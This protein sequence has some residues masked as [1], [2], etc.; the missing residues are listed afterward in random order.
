MEEQYIEERKKF[1]KKYLKS[2]EFKEVREA[3]FARDGYRCVAC[4]REGTP[5]N[6]LVCHH[7]CYKHL[8]EHNEAEIA[9][10]ITL[11]QLEHVALH[12]VKANL[13]WYSLKNERNY[14]NIENTE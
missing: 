4:G 11:C 3:V 8:G 2:K 14:E 6:P 7:K 12:R 9:D 5:K 13:N 1:H 10:C